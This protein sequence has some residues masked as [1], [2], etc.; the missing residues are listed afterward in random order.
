MLALY[1]ESEQFGLRDS[2]YFDDINEL[3]YGEED[4]ENNDRSSSKEKLDTED[5]T[6][7]LEMTVLN[8]SELDKID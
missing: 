4:D 1:E 7:D 8:P 6:A 2:Q 3:D 5:V